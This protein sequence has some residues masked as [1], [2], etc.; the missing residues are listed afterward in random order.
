MK[1]ILSLF[2]ITSSLAGMAYAQADISSLLYITNKIRSEIVNTTASQ[3]NLNEAQAKLEE[4]LDLLRQTAPAVNV[5]ENECYDFVY[6]KYYVSYNTIPSA[7]K[8]TALCKTV[9]DIQVLKYLYPKYYVSYDA[10]PS[11]EKAAAHSSADL[12]DK[13]DLLDFVYSKYYVSYDAVPSVEKAMALITSLP[14][15]SL[16]C[17]QKFYNIYY[18]SYDA[19]PSIEKAAGACH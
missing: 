8:A 6:P 3:S 7:E 15:G 9:G 1:N 13:L 10:V 12:K 16:G 2:L 14:E 4:A 11:I 19:V 5:N 17:L 18:S